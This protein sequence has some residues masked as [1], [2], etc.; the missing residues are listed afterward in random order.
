MSEEEA[1]AL[2]SSTSA[3]SVKYPLPKGLTIDNQ[4]FLS[5]LQALVFLGMIEN[6][7]LNQFTSLPPEEMKALIIKQAEEARTI[8]VK[9]ENGPIIKE[10]NVASFAA[11][12]GN[13][14]FLE[15]LFNNLDHDSKLFH[16]LFDH[17][18]LEE[19]S[20]P[21]H[22][23]T[24]FACRSTSARQVI[25]FLSSKGLFEHSVVTSA[26]KM[27]PLLI[28]AQEGQADAIEFAH[29]ECG[30]PLTYKSEKEGYNA[31]LIAVRFEHLDVIKYFL[32]KAKDSKEVRDLVDSQLMIRTS[33]DVE[34]GNESAFTLA[35]SLG[36]GS[37]QL[38]RALWDAGCHLTALNEAL[39]HARPMKILRC[40]T[41]AEADE[42]AAKE[43]SKV[44]RKFKNFPP[45]PQSTIPASSSLSLPS[46]PPTA[47]PDNNNN[48]N[49]CRA[50]NKLRKLMNSY[51]L[52]V[53]GERSECNAPLHVAVKAKDLEV[54][55][56][57]CETAGFDID[58][59]AIVGLRTPLD[60]ACRNG[61]I[62]IAEYLLNERRCEVNKRSKDDCFPLYSAAFQGNN[63]L[64]K[65]LLRCGAN[66]TLT[67]EGATPFFA[68]VSQ[69]NLETAKVLFDAKA[70]VTTHFKDR[71]PVQYARER[72]LVEMVAFLE[73][74]RIY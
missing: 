12:V 2:Y 66:T 62:E 44:Y 27:Y 13:I 49:N 15:L 26:S 45:I 70:D 32:K 37:V 74:N 11:L 38:V 65:L 33:K 43:P 1:A 58:R 19:D 9:V 14:E 5:D 30:M 73:E 31:F 17:T 20:R 50:S 60:I 16:N 59:D 46:P 7:R 18:K 71:G 57:L 51:K 48:N 35:C 36:T 34:L 47:H 21:C 22:T 63:E 68:A 52:S 23:L 54:V 3:S 25:K 56:F 67:W 29:E 10:V 42:A 39:E 55:K 69:G 6:G 24:E 4:R 28:L 64:I 61:F 72:G 8:S 53:G 40:K 41:E